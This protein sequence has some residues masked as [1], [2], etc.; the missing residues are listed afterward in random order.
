VEGIAEPIP[1]G[2]DQQHAGPRAESHNRPVEVQGPVLVGDV[3]S[4]GLD[5][6]PLG[7]EI[8]HGLRLYGGEGGI[9]DIIVSH[10]EIFNF[11][12]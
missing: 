8:S 11:R 4:R 9:L 5:F 3:R 12:M 6:G 2:Q 10:P 7:D 1:L